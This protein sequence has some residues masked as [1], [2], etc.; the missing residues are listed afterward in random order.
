MAQ[1][2]NRENAERIPLASCVAGLSRVPGRQVRYSVPGNMQQAISLVLSVQEAEKQERFNESFYTRFENS[3]RLVSRSPGQAYRDDGRPR[4]SADSHA[5]SHVRSQHGRAPH[6]SGKP[7]KSDTRN[8]RTKVALMCYECEG[9]GHFA[10]GMSY[11]AKK[12][13][14]P[15]RLA[16][17]E[18]HERALQT[19]TFPRQTPLRSKERRKE[20]KVKP[21]GKRIGSEK[22]DSSFHICG[23]DDAVNGFR[24]RSC[25]SK[26]LPLFP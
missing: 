8:A 12:E 13:R 23:P 17:K 5:A 9:V 6:S 26:V 3:A 25:W 11:A 18:E 7:T 19:L 22:A 16:G 24:F 2:I 10:G 20:G 1:R 4:R 21:S 15:L 14:K